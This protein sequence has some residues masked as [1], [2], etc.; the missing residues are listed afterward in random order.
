GAGLTAVAEWNPDGLAGTTIGGPVW[1]LVLVPLIIGAALAVRR[2]APLVMWVGIWA[3]ITLQNVITKHPPQGLLGFLFVLFAGA[4][5]LGAH[6]S[7]RRGGIGL[8]V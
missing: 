6:A 1:L 4:Y 2:R 8:V 7:L 3:S 5:S